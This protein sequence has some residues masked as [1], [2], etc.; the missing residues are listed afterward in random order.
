[1]DES[2]WSCTRATTAQLD[3]AEVLDSASGVSHTWFGQRKEI[4]LCS[5]PLHVNDELCSWP[6][7]GYVVYFAHPQP[8]S[9]TRAAKIFLPHL[10]SR[11]VVT[12]LSWDKCM[13]IFFSDS[14]PYQ[15]RLDLDCFSVSPKPQTSK[16]HQWLQ[17]AAWGQ[18][19]SVLLL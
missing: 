14:A 2:W 16:L 17:L 11:Q 6:F 5:L 13:E 8:S 18:R 15:L 19:Q 1:M 9:T 12:R 7:D 4:F 3:K 10:S